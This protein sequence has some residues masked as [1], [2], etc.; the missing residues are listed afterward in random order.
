MPSTRMLA[1][2]RGALVALGPRYATE[3]TGAIV[4]G[5]PAAIPVLGDF[6]T[7]VTTL[8]GTG[9]VERSLYESWH[10]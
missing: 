7:S 9:V 4:L 1:G 2:A 5:V 8:F 10:G 6:V 3:M